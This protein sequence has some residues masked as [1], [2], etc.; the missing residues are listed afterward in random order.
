ML[1]NRPAKVRLGMGSR[2][3]Y[4]MR[5]ASFRLLRDRLQNAANVK[6]SAGKKAGRFTV[7]VGGFEPHTNPVRM[8]ILQNWIQ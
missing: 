3:K 5:V 4:C 7:Q 1:P 8:D 2:E 6:V